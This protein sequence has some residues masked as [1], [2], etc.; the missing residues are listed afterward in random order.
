MA[1]ITTT[2]RCRCTQFRVSAN[3]GAIIKCTTHQRAAFDTLTLFLCFPPGTHTRIG[4]THS[5]ICS[6]L[7][8]TLLAV[9]L[10]MDSFFRFAA[11][12]FAG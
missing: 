11:H 9:D 4:R 2:G 12:T 3:V 10:V 8:R 5:S 1:T 7:Q 6:M